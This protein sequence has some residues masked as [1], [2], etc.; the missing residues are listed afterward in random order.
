MNQLMTG[1]K[2]AKHSIFSSKKI[3]KTIDYYVG[4]N[5]TF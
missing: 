2:N 4:E 5:G 3:K 1:G